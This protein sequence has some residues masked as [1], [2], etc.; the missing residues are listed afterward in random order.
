VIDDDEQ[1]AL[2]SLQ[3]NWIT[4]SDDVWEGADVYVPQLHGPRTTREITQGIDAARRSDPPGLV[5]EGVQGTGKTQLLSWVREQVQRDGGYFFL[6]TLAHGETF[7]EG[8]VEAMLDGLYRPHAGG[9][10][11]QLQVLL[12]RLG[13]RAGPSRV[14][15]AVAQGRRSTKAGLDRFVSDLSARAGLRPEVRDTVRALAM[16]RSDD[17]GA[18][19]VATAYFQAGDLDAE[20]RSE[21]GLGAPRSPER[22]VRHLSQILAATDHSVIAVDQLDPLIARAASSP[23]A[24]DSPQPDPRLDHLVNQV[25]Q[26]LMGLREGTHRTLILLACIPTSWKLIQER[27]VATVADRFRRPPLTLKRIDSAE[28]ARAIVEKHLAARYRQLNFTPPY[29]SWPVQ[30][31]AFDTAQQLTPRDLLERLAAHVSACLDADAVAE[32][33]RFDAPAAVVASGGQADPERPEYTSL[34]RRFEQLRVTADVASAL[35]P[36]QEDLMMPPLLRAGIQAWI[37]ER[38]PAAKYYE[39]DPPPSSNPPSHAGLRHIVDEHVDAQTR[40]AFR[41]IAHSNPRATQVRLTRAI[42]QSGIDGGDDVRRLFI[43]RRDDWPS[44]P[45]TKQLV[46][47]FA[48]RGGVRLAVDVDDLRTFEALRKL[49]QDNDP[50]LRPWLV[51][52]QTASSTKLLREALAEVSA[53]VPNGRSGA[54]VDNAG[55]TGGAASGAGPPADQRPDVPSISVGAVDGVPFWLELESLRKH[56]AVFAGSGSGKTV[57]LR[58]LVEECALQGV[59]SIVLDPN[60]DLARLGDAWPEPPP[61]WQDGD[62]ERAR[63]YLDNTDVVVW[64]PR[65]ERGRPLTFQPLPDFASVLDDA[66]EFRQAVDV[67]VA[68]LAPRAGAAGR[69]TKAERQRAVLHEAVDYFARHGAGSFGDFIDV[70]SHLPDNASTI[71]SAP[72]MAA[73][74]A[75]TLQAARVNDPL[76]GGKGTP[77]DPGALLAPADGKRA[78]ISVISFVG[79]SE[80][81]RPGFVSQLQM[82]LFGWFKRHPAADRPLGGLLVMDEAQTLAPSGAATPSTEST[83]ILASQ[84]RKYGLGLVFATQAPKGLH[85][86]IPGNAATQLFGY[87]NSPAQISTA[88]EI[89]RRKGGDV[90]DISRLRSGEFYVA[91]EGAAFRQ[92]RTSNCLSHHPPS[93]LSTDEV[94]DRARKP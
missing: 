51:A 14:V 48:R 5:L 90:A 23:G 47:D 94:I 61:G 13:E 59:S 16:S 19:D 35:D 53:A 80:Q 52:R 36:H 70:L 46:D 75:H 71:P 92:I 40:T 11:T 42:E 81:Q 68:V 3:L 77:V 89:A 6:V 26:G 49:L 28:V 85:N 31:A 79:L 4:S 27:G 7:W 21:Y 34:D 2:A 76:F 56:V 30:P 63:D 45:K 33:S 57:L 83:L 9:G 91:V 54:A 37:A 87:L 69:T 25:A 1:R 39:P 8:V 15:Q 43:L 64:T 10:G 24:V 41:A 67:A 29:P 50:A 55:Q 72:A 78:R 58:R 82:A 17:V 22:T 65:R 62:A 84:A 60:N 18:Q 88:Q 12:G 20:A 86:R 93:P 74:M 66:D 73:D 44:G 38:G 32:L